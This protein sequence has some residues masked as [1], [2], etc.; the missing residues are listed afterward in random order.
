MTTD[1]TEFGVSTD[2]NPDG[3]TNENL[4]TVK[5]AME[6]KAGSTTVANAQFALPTA[7]T[8]RESQSKYDEELREHQERTAWLQREIAWEHK[9]LIETRNRFTQE[10][11][12]DGDYISMG[13]RLR[14]L[15]HALNRIK[16]VVGDLQGL[17]DAVIRYTKSDEAK[18]KGI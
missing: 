8:A 5:T 11:R 7:L 10:T 13:D 3:V 17:E 6:P 1:V 16:E 14:P 4:D 12:S 9:N 2:K 15:I 18:H